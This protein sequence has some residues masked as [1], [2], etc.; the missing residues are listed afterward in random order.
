M[1]TGIIIQTQ[2]SKYLTQGNDLYK[3][4]STTNAHAYWLSSPSEYDYPLTY[5]MKVLHN[6]NIN[7]YSNSDTNCGFRPIVCL[8][9]SISLKEVELGKSYQI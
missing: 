8:K 3:I 9:S 7:Y 6:E 5:V 2:T 4:S 1:Q